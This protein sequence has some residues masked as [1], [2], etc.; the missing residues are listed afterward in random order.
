MKKRDTKRPYLREYA[1]SSHITWRPDPDLQDRFYRFLEVH[2]PAT[3]SEY[4][5]EILA[6]YLDCADRYGLDPITLRPKDGKL[7]V[8]RIK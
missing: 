8:K 4:L 2:P 6:Y 3:R 7:A 1:K 5:N